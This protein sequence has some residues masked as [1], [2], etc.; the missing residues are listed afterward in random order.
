MRF[1]QQASSREYLQRFARLNRA[2][3]ARTCWNESCGA[4]VP[5][6]T[7]LISSQS[8]QFP[9]LHV[10]ASIG[11]KLPAINPK[12]QSHDLLF[13]Q[14]IGKSPFKIEAVPLTAL[15]AFSYILVWILDTGCHR[16]IL[17]FAYDG[18]QFVKSDYANSTQQQV[19]YIRCL[20]RDTTLPMP[21]DMG[22]VLSAHKRVHLWRKKQAFVQKWLYEDLVQPL[23]TQGEKQRS[24]DFFP[25]ED[26][27]QRG[28]FRGQRAW[29]LR[30]VSRCKSFQAHVSLCHVQSYANIVGIAKWG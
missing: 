2:S 11:S 29:N 12:F 16:A 22:S 4:C 10:L 26:Q 28:S 3:S 14:L 24:S 23:R 27:T 1:L 25:S 15:F 9:I 5:S 17:G 8:H 20:W 13:E 30:C 21:N 6:T 18:A 19:I 7:S